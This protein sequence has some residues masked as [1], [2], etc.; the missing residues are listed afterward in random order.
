[1]SV[2]ASELLIEGEAPVD[3]FVEFVPGAVTARSPTQL[4]WRR[5]R[6]D[7]VAMAS[8]TF[9]LL[10]ILIAI[11]APLLVSLLGLPGPSVQ[12]PNLTDA[13]GTPLGPTGAHPF[14]VDPLGEDVMSR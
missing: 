13:F 10:L 8:A 7:R 14:G 12:N 1:M 11:F 6:S 4:F 5:F 9:I 3:A 2:G